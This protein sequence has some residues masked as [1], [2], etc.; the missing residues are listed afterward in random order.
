MKTRIQAA[1]D[2]HGDKWRN[3][4]IQQYTINLGLTRIC[5]V[6]QNVFIFGH[7]CNLTPTLFSL[8]QQMV[9][10]SDPKNTREKHHQALLTELIFIVQY[11]N[12]KL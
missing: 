9:K 12:N 2:F 11:C 3:M 7:L 6:L 5:K 1:N 10:G 8:S 4:W